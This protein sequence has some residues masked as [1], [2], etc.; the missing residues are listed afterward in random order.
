ML[1]DDRM[2]L[3]IYLQNLTRYPGGGVV[4][5]ASRFANSLTYLLTK[6]CDFPSPF[7]D[8]KK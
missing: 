3:E 1:K 4:G 5:C 8:L 2:L 6:I 7:Y